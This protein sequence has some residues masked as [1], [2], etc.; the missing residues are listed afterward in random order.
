MW[1]MGKNYLMISIRCTGISKRVDDWNGLGA[2][3][4][5]IVVYILCKFGGLLSSTSADNAAW[6]CTAGV[7]QHSGQFIYIH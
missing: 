1:L 6:L 7:D 3:K 4:A 2:F 5:A